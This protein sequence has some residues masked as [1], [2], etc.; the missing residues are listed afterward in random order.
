MANF[1]D[2]R[3]A[4]NEQLTNYYIA[5]LWHILGCFGNYQLE[6]YLNQLLIGIPSINWN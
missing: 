1:L 4:Y 5:R 6:F 2:A 3:D